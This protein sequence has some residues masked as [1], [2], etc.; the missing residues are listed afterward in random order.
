MFMLYTLTACVILY[1]MFAAFCYSVF[2]RSPIKY[3]R[4]QYSASHNRNFRKIDDAG[5]FFEVSRTAV[6]NFYFFN[7]AFPDDHVSHMVPQYGKYVGYFKPS[8]A[9][10]FDN[11]FS[12]AFIGAYFVLLFYA[13][14]GFILERN[15][16]I[17]ALLLYIMLRS[18]FIFLFNPVESLLYSSVI[19]LPMMMLLF[20]YFIRSRF[21]FKAAL[22]VVFIVSLIGS[23]AA[24]FF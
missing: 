14:K 18:V 5:S 19:I 23:N 8:P 16:I 11:V 1:V 10:Y 15:K 21:R 9:G 17:F 22:L 7:F 4:Y 2:K 3:Y 13:S 20:Y 24:F 12:I 6:L